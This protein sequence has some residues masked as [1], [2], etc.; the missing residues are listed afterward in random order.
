MTHA[1]R[2][3]VNARARA[4]EARSAR[5]AFYRAKLADFRR[6]FPDRSLPSHSTISRW[7]AEARQRWPI[8]T[9]VPQAGAAV[10]IP[11]A[12]P[13]HPQEEPQCTPS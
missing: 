7:V 13:R 10:P 8:S 2:P 4:R 9:I 6:R 12:S 3:P 1:P 11:A 5:I